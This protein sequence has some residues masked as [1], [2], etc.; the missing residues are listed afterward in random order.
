MS[1]PV[2]A[3]CDRHDSHGLLG[4]SAPVSIKHH[5]GRRVRFLYLGLKQRLGT[6]SS[7]G[8]F[9]NVNYT[10]SSGALELHPQLVPFNFLN[11]A[12]GPSNTLVRFDTAN[13]RAAGE[14]RTVPLGKP[15]YPGHVAVDH[16]GNT[17]VANW[18]EAGIK[19]GTQPGSLTKIGIKHHRLG[20]QCPKK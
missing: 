8:F 3:N 4:T 18:H 5:G 6:T 14:Y 13:L 11:V 17:W 9:L 20:V 15:G 12:C 1:R 16:F 7:N 19:D 10:N 2:H